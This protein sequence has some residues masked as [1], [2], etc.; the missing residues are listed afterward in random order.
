[1]ESVKKKVKGEGCVDR[2]DGKQLDK[3]SQVIG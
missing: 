2:A 1:M 3:F